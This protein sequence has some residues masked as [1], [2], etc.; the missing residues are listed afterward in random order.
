M[1]CGLI[2]CMRVGWAQWAGIG[3]GVIGQVA[4]ARTGQRTV[5]DCTVLP[6]DTSENQTSSV[7]A[8]RPQLGPVPVPFLR[9]V[10]LHA[11]QLGRSF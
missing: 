6:Y 11:G 2:S 8:I 5:R 10:A 4:A 9:Y 1:V 7:N 3:L